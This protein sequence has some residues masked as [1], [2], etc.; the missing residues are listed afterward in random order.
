MAVRPSS[1][2]ASGA[3]RGSAKTGASGTQP[4]APMLI[5]RGKHAGKPGM[6]LTRPFTL[7]GS[8]QR[9]HLNLVS[10]SISKTHACIINTGNGLYIADLYSRTHTLVNDKPVREVEPP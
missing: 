7:V 1:S 5:P 9:A 8:R 4:A 6:T 3:S 2:S 10:D